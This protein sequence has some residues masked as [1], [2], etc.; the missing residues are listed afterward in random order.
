MVSMLRGMTSGIVCSAC[1]LQY[2]CEGFFLHVDECQLENGTGPLIPGR[3]R[4][5]PLM[6]MSPIKCKPPGMDRQGSQ[7]GERIF[8]FG[9]TSS[10]IDGDCSTEAGYRS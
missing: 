4:L 8:E 9:R 6:S 7:D 10:I 3:P 5:D 1:N 2:D